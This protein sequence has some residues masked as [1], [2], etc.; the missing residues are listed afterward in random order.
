MRG[1]LALAL[2]LFLPPNMPMREAAI[3]ATFGVTIFSVVVQGL[4]MSTLLRV[5]GIRRPWAHRTIDRL[6]RKTDMSGRDPRQI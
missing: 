4:T 1:A 2:A 5:L 6:W 3:I